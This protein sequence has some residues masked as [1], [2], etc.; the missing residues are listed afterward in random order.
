M[1]RVRVI[2]CVVKFHVSFSESGKVQ[3]ITLFPNGKKSPSC[4][5][6]SENAVSPNSAADSLFD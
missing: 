4:S 6:P 3:G 5:L 2:V 1:H